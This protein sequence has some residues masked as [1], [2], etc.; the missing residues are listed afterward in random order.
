MDL[1][2]GPWTLRT[3][4]LNLPT[5]THTHTHTPLMPYCILLLLVTHIHTHPM[6][7]CILLLLV[8][9]IHTHTP[10]A[11]LYTPSTSHT[12]THTHPMPYCILLLL[13]THIHTP[14]HPMP[15]YILLLLIIMAQGKWGDVIYNSHVILIN[16]LT[17][18]FQSV[19]RDYHKTFELDLLICGTQMFAFF[20][21]W[22]SAF[23]P[24]T[25][26]GSN[27]RKLGCSK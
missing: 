5:H 13:V 23:L 16:F 11:I 26:V 20:S 21:S 12:H 19:V 15:Y 1:L 25:R 2:K 27:T 24:H 10:Y 4:W 14:A 17:C 3:L 6:P 18:V 22:M 7:Y 9:H 8:T